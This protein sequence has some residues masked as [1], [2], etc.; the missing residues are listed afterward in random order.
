MGTLR[1]PGLGPIVG[2]TAD[3]TC[4]IWIRAG[5]PADSGA[6]L[7]AN[8]RTIGLIGIVESKGGKGEIGD[9]WYFRLAREFDRTGA[10]MLG[11]DVDLGRWK[12]DIAREKRDEGAA[13]ARAA[14]AKPLTPDKVYRVRVGTLTLDDPWA[15]DANVPD[16]KIRDRLPDI[17]VLKEELLSLPAIESEATFRT[18][19]AGSVGKLS[20]LLGSCRYPGLL[21][22]VKE[23]DRIFGPMQ[24]HFEAGNPWGDAARFT[25]MVGDQIYAD[26]LNK[27]VPILRADTYQEF[28]ER[29]RTA[30]GAPNLRKLLR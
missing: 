29:Y 24:K 21:W 12:S 13:N 27:M 17:D 1:K 7:D 9:A 28:Q 18:F 2:A 22:K 25:L 15:D 4:R 23:A 8:R 19:P 11:E 10:F 20:F 16:Y 3:T 5:D 6:T 30:F 14:T 26:V